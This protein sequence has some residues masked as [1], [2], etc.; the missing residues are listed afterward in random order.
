VPSPLPVVVESP[1]R[2]PTVVGHELRRRGT[3][4]RAS[5]EGRVLDLDDPAA[6]AEIARAS[7]GARV[8]PAYDAALSVGQL[9]RFPDLVA[10]M[11]G[12]DRLLGPEG[13]LLLVEPTGRPGIAALLLDSV[14]ARTP[15]VRGLHLGRDVPAALRGTTL[16]LDDLERFTMP[17]PV[18][19]LRHGVEVHAA[20]RPV[21][22]IATAAVAREASA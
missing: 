17:T 18:T 13:R 8:V 22:A 14:W 2:F 1:R 15:W 21:P 19:S 7:A 20:R 3:A 6:R 9:V 4:L 11:R 16:L 10:A 12:I 5:T